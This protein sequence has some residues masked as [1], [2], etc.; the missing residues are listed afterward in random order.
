MR[1]NWL[2]KGLWVKIGISAA[3]AEAKKQAPRRLFSLKNRQ[4]GESVG[5]CGSKQKQIAALVS[6]SGKRVKENRL[7]SAWL[8]GRVVSPPMNRRGESSNPPDF[9]FQPTE[10][11]GGKE[12]ARKS[13]PYPPKIRLF[14]FGFFLDV[15][16]QDVLILCFFDFF[17]FVFFG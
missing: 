14:C 1:K 13:I 3:C 10:F 12:D 6:K 8:A 11:I 9:V 16:F 15:F 5:I 7:A 4:L 17:A 2:S